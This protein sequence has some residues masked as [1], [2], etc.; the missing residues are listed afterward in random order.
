MI[1]VDPADASR[2]PAP[3]PRLV[4]ER[5]GYEVDIPLAS[6]ATSTAMHTH[7]SVERRMRRPAGRWRA[8]CPQPFARLTLFHSTSIGR[9]SLGRRFSFSKTVSTSCACRGISAWAH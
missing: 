9:E 1:E 8:S 5:T 4:F 7:T 6:V 3:M 2:Y